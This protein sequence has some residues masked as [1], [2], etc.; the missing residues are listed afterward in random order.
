MFYAQL[1]FIVG[2]I[3]CAVGEV[4]S[5][6]YLV[7]PGDRLHSPPDGGRVVGVLGEDVCCLLFV[8]VCLLLVLRCLL[9]LVCFLLVVV[10]LVVCVFICLFVCSFV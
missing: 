5:C 1:E 9:L 3:G 10:R 7:G 4:K 6:V 8:A 2:R